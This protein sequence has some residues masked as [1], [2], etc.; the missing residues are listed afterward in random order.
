MSFQITIQPSQHQ[1][2]A[3]ADKSVLDAAPGR[4][5]CLTLQLPQRR[6]LNL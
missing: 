1:F 4:W 6:L 5:H 3:D 2:A